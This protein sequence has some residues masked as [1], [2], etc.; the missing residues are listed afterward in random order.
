MGENASPSTASS[1][2]V[3]IRSGRAASRLPFLGILFASLAYIVVYGD[4]QTL[5]SVCHTAFSPSSGHSQQLEPCPMR[6]GLGHAPGH[7]MNRVN[8]STVSKERNV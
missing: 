2:W 6:S 8:V 5:E 3:G 4:C 7:G 1:Q